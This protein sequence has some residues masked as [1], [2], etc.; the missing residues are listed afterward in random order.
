MQKLKIDMWT[1]I[2]VG[3]INRMGQLQLVGQSWIQLNFFLL[4]F[5]VN[6]DRDFPII[7]MR[8]SVKFRVNLISNLSPCERLETSRM[9]FSLILLSSFLCSSTFHV[10]FHFHL[11]QRAKL[12]LRYCAQLSSCVEPKLSNSALNF[13]SSHETCE[14]LENAEDDDN[15]KRLRRSVALSR[16]KSSVGS[17]F[18]QQFTVKT[19]RSNELF[20]VRAL[21]F[22]N[23]IQKIKIDQD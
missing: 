9:R 12:F 13:F 3:E 2:F 4:N 17:E 7:V 1:F 21:K 10:H 14:T 15:K 22:F 20:S 11:Q 5:K 23:L 8:I 18:H 16:S 6:L 19:W